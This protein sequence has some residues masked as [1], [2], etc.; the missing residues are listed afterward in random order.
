MPVYCQAHGVLPLASSQL[1]STLH[2][3]V[4]ECVSVCLCCWD[5]SLLL[6]LLTLL[7]CKQDGDVTLNLAAA[8]HM[9]EAM[10]TEQ[11]EESQMAVT[12]PPTADVAPD[13]LGTPWTKEVTDLATCALLLP[14][15]AGSIPSQ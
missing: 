5:D 3:R 6:T 15:P 7:A 14:E 1:L 8:A 2:I 9:L 4:R 12:P 13:D 11:P 10:V